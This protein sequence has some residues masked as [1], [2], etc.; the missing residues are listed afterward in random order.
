MPPNTTP[1][2]ALPFEAILHINMA[3]SNCQAAVE[4]TSST[5]VADQLDHEPRSDGK[6]RIDTSESTIASIPHPPRRAGDSRL[7]PLDNDV[8][9]N[10][11]ES[12][13]TQSSIFMFN[14]C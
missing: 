5:G 7:W 1:S 9:R 6:L 11:S 10:A 12:A 14:H 3:Q 8:K 4:S 2:T 13:T